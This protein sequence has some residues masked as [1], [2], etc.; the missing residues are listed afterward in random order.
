METMKNRFENHS[1]IFYCIIA[2][3]VIFLPDVSGQVVYDD[4]LINGNNFGKAAF[5]LWMKSDFKRIKGLIVLM[6]G[7][8]GDGRDMVY[9][10]AWQNMATRHNF[11]LLGCYYMDKA[12]N[13]MDIESYA[14]VKNGSGQA[15]LDM[16]RTF[17][18]KSEHPELADAPLALWGMSAGGEFNYEFACWKPDRVIAFV[19]NKGGI[20]YSSLAPPAV[21]DVPGLFI[22]GE[23]DSPFRNNI[24]KGIFS[25]NRRFGAKW[26]FAEEPGI[27]HEFQKSEIFGRFFFDNIIPLRLSDDPL[28]R[29]DSLQKIITKGYV[30]IITTHQILP[31][32]DSKQVE[33][34]SWFPDKQIAEGWLDF[35]K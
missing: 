3:G 7:S 1:G 31:E 30:G 8:N 13:Y 24:I 27:A 21:W 5:R 33:I 23:K 34:T 26:I 19:V 11:A 17:S 9:D 32:S 10:T 15:L 4:S 6:P 2:L 29:S 14:D 20:Y 22:T 12:H 16:L 35:I 25:I 28:N 18:K